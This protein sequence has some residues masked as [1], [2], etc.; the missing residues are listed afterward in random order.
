MT[1]FLIIIAAYLVGMFS[2]LYICY[3]RKPQFD[4][5]CLMFEA[6]M[7]KRQENQKATKTPKTEAPAKQPDALDKLVKEE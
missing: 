6:A 3:A 2:A 7:K 4:M 1:D 5:F